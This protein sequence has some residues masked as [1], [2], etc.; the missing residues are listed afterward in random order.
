MPLPPKSGSF[1]SFSGIR[2]ELQFSGI[3]PE[4]PVGLASMTMVYSYLEMIGCSLVSG[5][6]SGKTERNCISRGSSL[7]LCR[8]VGGEIGSH[9]MIM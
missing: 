7:P 5:E 9:V 6:V 2:E 1:S 4:N 3:F 8:D